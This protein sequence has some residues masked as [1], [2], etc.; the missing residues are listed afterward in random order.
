MLRLR[1]VNVLPQTPDLSKLCSL[2]DVI[3]VNCCLWLQGELNRQNIVNLRLFYI[4]KIVNNI[5]DWITDSGIPNVT[6]K[7][8]T[9]Q[10]KRYF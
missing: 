10:T 2:S 8:P 4:T 6:T 3:C 1:N 7:P 5:L 9:S